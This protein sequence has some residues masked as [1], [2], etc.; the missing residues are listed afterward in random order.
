M[1][2]NNTKL[3]KLLIIGAGGTGKEVLW[4][5]NDINKISNKFEVIGFLDEKKSLHGKKIHN[6][7]ILGNINWIKNKQNLNCVVAI[8]DGKKRE[9][10][11][12][13][14]KKKK[15]KF[16]KIIHPSVIIADNVK[17]GKGIIIQA[18]S[19]IPPDSK[20]GNFVLINLK[21]HIGHDCKI[22]DFVSIMTN[23]DVNGQT[24]IKKGA[25]IASGVV[26]RN[27]L[28]IGKWSVI[29]LGSVVG[30]EIEDYSLYLGNP[31]RQIKKIKSES[32]RPSL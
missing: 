19:I 2:Q 25:Y 7:P 23:V 6:I 26:I 30:S 9:L 12:K 29:G 24:I 8:G 13:Q 10:I 32:S 3:K 5:I 4:S 22:E 20:I 17:M 16:P 28:T 15:L 31:A 27:L 11:V 14:L 1:K 21:S 18:G